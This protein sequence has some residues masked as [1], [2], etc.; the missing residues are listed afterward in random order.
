MTCPPAGAIRCAVPRDLDQVAA[1]WTA[2]TE[3]HGSFDGLFELR[4]DAGAEIRAL[5]VGQ[6]QSP[7][8]ETFVWDGAS[9]LAGFCSVRIDRAPPILAEVVRAENTA[10][11]VRADARRRGIGRALVAAAGDWLRSRG[12]KRVEVRVASRNPEGQA[13]WRAL[14][15]GDLMD[16]LHR[17]L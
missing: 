4:S 17:R 16:V 1:L 2:I 6:L 5:L 11:G 8:V 15:F 14:G 10:R 3:H 12:V 9:G 13:F 7:N